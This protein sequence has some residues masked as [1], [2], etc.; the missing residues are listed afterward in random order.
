MLPDGRFGETLRVHNYCGLVIVVYVD[1]TTR[2][3][4]ERLG[5]TQSRVRALISTR[6]LTARRLGS[7][8]VVECSSVERQAELMSASANS[9]AMSPRIAW[10]AAAMTDRQSTTWLASSERSRLRRRLTAART[11]EMWQRWLACRATDVKRYRVAESDLEAV[12]NADGV[13]RTGVS[14]AVPYELELGS[15]GTGDAYVSPATAETLIRQ[16]YLLPTMNGNLTL[17]TVINEHHIT[18]ARLLIGE[19]VTTRLMVAVDL[20]GEADARARSAGRDLLVQLQDDFH[21]GT[22]A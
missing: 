21:A 8:W 7:Q 14:A 19:T 6:M 13:V 17:R 18:T 2:Q 4:A 5:V 9:R 10:A 16:Y 3:A 1:M 11:G 15:G 12:L 22:T 20:A